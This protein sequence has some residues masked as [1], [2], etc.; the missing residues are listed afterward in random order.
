MNPSMNPPRLSFD[1]S[2]LPKPA[3][4]AKCARVPTP[5]AQ[6]S[7]NRSLRRWLVRYRSS[8]GYTTPYN[9]VLSVWGDPQKFQ[10]GEPFGSQA[11]YEGKVNAGQSR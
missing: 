4:V 2:T 6:S 3:L 5:H 9:P 11:G 7:A 1:A 8:F 10:L